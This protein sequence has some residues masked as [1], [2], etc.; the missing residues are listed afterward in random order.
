MSLHITEA[1]KAIGVSAATLK[2]WFRGAK[3]ADV[4][5]DRNGYRIFETE[6]IE[7]IRAFANRRTEPPPPW[8]SPQH[9]RHTSS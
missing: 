7:R 5:R 4:A 1:A 3:V 9:V 8:P 6:D 2:R